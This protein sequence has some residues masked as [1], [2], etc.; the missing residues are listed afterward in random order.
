MSFSSEN[1]EQFDCMY[2]VNYTYL[3]NQNYR[4][5]ISVCLKKCKFMGIFRP[6]V[7]GKKLC[8]QNTNP[9]SL[10]T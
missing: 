8:L 2:R 5:T 10:K 1:A 7:L 3:D 9:F 6:R 4:G